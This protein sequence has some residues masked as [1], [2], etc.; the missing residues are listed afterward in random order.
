MGET[1]D[2]IGAKTDVKS[3]AAG[4][5]S[6]KK[7]AVVDKKDQVFS[8]VTGTMPDTGEMKEGAGRVKGMAESN[9]LGLAIGGAAVG[10]L[11]GLLLPST[12]AEDQ[13][14]G[15]VADDLKD[16]VKET[17][18]EALDRGMHVAEE[19]GRAAKET[20]KEEGRSESEELASTLKESAQEVR[21]SGGSQ[22]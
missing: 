7:D 2:A 20:V 5:V 3:R 15:S 21:T 22:V 4:Y 18:Q 9:P 12:S 1:V 14:M 16:R 19:A 8:K 11:A 17:G 6:D 10:F 13:R